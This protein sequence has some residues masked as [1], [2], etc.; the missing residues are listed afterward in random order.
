MAST[1]NGFIPFSTKEFPTAAQVAEEEDL[2]IEGWA[3][4]AV[5]DR[6]GDLVIPEAFREAIDAYLGS[7]VLLYMH[8]KSQPIGAITA[9][10][11]KDEGI[12]VKGY[13]TPD[14][15][16]AKEEVIPAIKKGILNSFSIGFIPKEGRYEPK[17]NIYIITKGE[18]LEISVVSVAANQEAKFSVGKE[19]TEDEEWDTLR[20][21]WKEKALETKTKTT[22]TQEEIAEMELAELI[23][24]LEKKIADLESKVSTKTVEDVELTA[25]LDA[26]R[27]KMAD[28]EKK[29]VEAVEAKIL[30]DAEAAKAVETKRFTDLEDSMKAMAETLETAK[31][32]AEEAKALAAKPNG[33]IEFPELPVN[34][35][36]KD[37]GSD[38]DNL[39]I[40]Q[41]L[42]TTIAVE[43]LPYFGELP[44]QVK[45]V[46][47]DAAFRTLAGRRIWEDIRANAIVAGL[48]PSLEIP[49]DIYNL[50]YDA[51]SMTA[52]FT[53]AGTTVSESTLT[54]S[55]VQLQAS[56]I[57]AKVG[58]T[59]EDEADAL[60][61]VVAQIRKDLLNAM[62]DKVDATIMTGAGSVGWRGI[63]HYAARGGTTPFYETAASATALVATDVQDAR[64]GMGK[65]GHKN[66]DSVLFLSFNKYGQ[67]VKDSNVITV[68]KFGPSAT[69][70]NGELAKVMGMPILV[71][72][73]ATGANTTATVAGTLCY[74]PGFVLGYRSQMMVEV[75]KNIETQKKMI[76]F[77][78]RA[79][80]K[81]VYPLTSSQIPTTKPIVYSLIN[82]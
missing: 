41:Q 80:F 52:S 1:L 23:K 33:R 60:V 32:D 77:S 48:F 64:I 2:V 45:A 36:W 66:N 7:P 59:Y 42:K 79:D 81:P 40:M 58:F 20:T 15:K 67:L 54:I 4:K 30:A 47:N 17:D 34:A 43:D 14:I 46:S 74:L 6:V 63:E 82:L 26:L 39:F 5:K 61:P 68:D 37:Y 12:Y 16:F 9:L 13:I 73:A 11:L 49:T 3:N 57:M 56:K 10:D 50:P 70:H 65:Y 8:N 22:P 24:S 62:V 78:V 28:F 71:T 38:L 55:P 27:V 72:D 25:E 18:L 76:V 29:E 51:S 53:D 75:D 19:F 31:A 44:E 35:I 21:Q 69:I